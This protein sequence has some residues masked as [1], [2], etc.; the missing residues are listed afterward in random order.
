MY[1]LDTYQGVA[2]KIYEEVRKFFAPAYKKAKTGA[3]EIY[4]L[5]AKKDRVIVEVNGTE[6]NTYELIAGYAGM[7]ITDWFDSLLGENEIY[8][9]GAS[10]KTLDDER[11]RR[12]NAKDI[13]TY[14]WELMLPEMRNVKDLF[15][16]SQGIHHYR[17][18]AEVKNQNI[19]YFVNG[20]YVFKGRYIDIG[21]IEW[22]VVDNAVD[23][24]IL[25]DKL[26]N[27]DQ[28]SD[29]TDIS[30][31][32]D[33][34]QVDLR[35]TYFKIR[36]ILDQ[37]EFK[38]DTIIKDYLAAYIMSIPIMAAI[39]DVNITFVTGDAESGK[40]SLIYGLLGGK[41]N[42]AG[43]IPPIL[44]A[45][46]ASTDSTAAAMYQEFDCKTILCVLDE[47]DQNEYRSKQ[48]SDRISEL[49]KHMYSIPMGGCTV[50][51]GGS[52]RELSETYYLNMP[53]IMAGTTVPTDSIFLSRIFVVYTKK[54]PGK[55]LDYNITMSE[56]VKLRR[57][58]TIGLIPYIPQL[59]FLRKKL[60]KDLMKAGGDIATL[61]TRFLECVLTP[62]TIYEYIGIG[63]AEELYK[64]VL[65]CYKDRLN[66]IH[67]TETQSDLINICLY[68]EGIKI[69]NEAGITDNVSARSLILSG[70]VS[71]LNNS[72]CG[73]Y[74]LPEKSW[75]VI[76]W[77]Q[78]KYTILKYSRFNC[79]E[80]T[81]MFELATKTPFTN[82]D[83]TDEDHN[84][85][86][87]ELGLADV[88]AK[89][90][91]SVVD[92]RYLVRGDVM[93]KVPTTQKT[94]SYVTCTP[95]NE[96]QQ[97]KP[98]NVKEYYNVIVEDDSFKNKKDNDDDNEVIFD[99]EL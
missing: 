16:V 94:T 26:T 49:M 58:I 83:I 98:S 46:Y 91:Y 75:I 52:I 96:N 17:L 57:D 41:Y 9:S 1:A 90:S 82:R 86:I 85:I 89:T 76:V 74:Y 55:K 39:G 10:G 24:N 19:I 38:Y 37:W 64:D 3:G 81:S 53:I 93:S 43:S 5:W 45:A 66:S 79:I 28:W 78:V 40:T 31:L 27:V 18:P 70:D 4:C 95:D 23:N 32:N 61:S 87:R 51:R 56:I 33:A 12:R 36:S 77:R 68:A 42:N 73:V 22:S 92:V 44:E 84:Y 60:S 34:P 7:P 67:G 71:I 88:K 29:V 14:V 50:V 99:F 35:E 59:L 63:S 11:T 30:V 80:E 62:L 72:K 48:Q 15:K 20:K 65:S 2:K 13:M 21:N 47:I 25:F 54:V 69:L 8:L 6:K 97:N